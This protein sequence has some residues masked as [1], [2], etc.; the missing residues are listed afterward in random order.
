[1]DNCNCKQCLECK[2]RAGRER[3]HQ[4][5][6]QVKRPAMSSPSPMSYEEFEAMQDARE[7]GDGRRRE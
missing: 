3:Y 4:R 1:M 6:S 5:K 2:R 7:P